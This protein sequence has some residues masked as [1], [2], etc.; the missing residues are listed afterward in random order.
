[1]CTSEAFCRGQLPRESLEEGPEKEV[2]YN[3]PEG[4]LV[5]VPKGQRS[6][7][8]FVPPTKPRRHEGKVSR[9]PQ[10]SKWRTSRATQAIVHTSLSFK[11]FQDLKISAPLSTDELPATIAEIEA[12]LEEREGRLADAQARKQELAG[13]R[14]EEDLSCERREQEAERDAEAER[15]RLRRRRA[16]GRVEEAL[17]ALRDAG[18]CVAALRRA[19]DAALRLGATL[20]DFPEAS[21]A[22]ELAERGAASDALLDVIIGVGA[23]VTELREAQEAEDARPGRDQPESEAGQA[24]EDVEGA[25]TAQEVP[26]PVEVPRHQ[27]KAS[28]QAPGTEA[29]RHHAA[30]QVHTWVC[31]V[32]GDLIRRCL[33]RNTCCHD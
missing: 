5:V 12:R 16:I 8:Y 31:M 22:V 9:R 3:N 11:L 24:G 30:P 2:R 26:G 1:M 17:D 21:E 25:T 19:V 7:E 29:T 18:G 32:T 4:S 6:E 14:L 28:I 33:L 13:R 23:A 27:L 15:G 20:A 10:T